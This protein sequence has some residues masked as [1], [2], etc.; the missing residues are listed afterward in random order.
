MGSRSE[1]SGEAELGRAESEKGGLRSRDKA[2]CIPSFISK[3]YEIL[4][5]PLH[6]FRKTN[7]P[8]SSSGVRQAPI[9][10]SRTSKS[11]RKRS[12]PSTSDIRTSHLSL[13]SSICMT[14]TRSEGSRNTFSSTSSSARGRSITQLI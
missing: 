8:L 7:T 14:S 11:S 12:S 10:T 3:T 6:L 9:S 2:H 1:S 13:G 5:V 4:E